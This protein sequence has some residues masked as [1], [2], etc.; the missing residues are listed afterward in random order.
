[1]PPI[2]DAVATN[3]SP[4]N[5][6][7][8]PNAAPEG[9]PVGWIKEKSTEKN[10]GRTFTTTMGAA[11]DLE[12][13]GTRRMLV[14]AAYWCVGLENKI[15]DSSNVEIV[16]EYKPSPFRFGGAKKGVKPADLAL[17]AE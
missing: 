6:T 2:A 14:N 1:M 9:M 15:P 12:R 16:G 7:V 3:A 17:K 4:D 8:E 10:L 13:E 11:T 5:R